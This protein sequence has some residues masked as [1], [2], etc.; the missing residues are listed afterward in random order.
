MVAYERLA[1]RT[2]TSDPMNPSHLSRDVHSVWLR[3]CA[4]THTTVRHMPQ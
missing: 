1:S 3:T 4:T 2:V